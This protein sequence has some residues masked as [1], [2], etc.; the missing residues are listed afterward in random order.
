MLPVAGNSG[1]RQQKHTENASG[2]I[3]FLPPGALV[4]IR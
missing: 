1:H 4:Y 2:G 3:F